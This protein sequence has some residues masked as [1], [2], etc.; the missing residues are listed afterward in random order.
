MCSRV[1][2]P[3]VP[4]IVYVC[5]LSDVPVALARGESSRGRVSM[6]QPA[7]PSRRSRHSVKIRKLGSPASRAHGAPVAVAAALVRRL[8]GD[9]RVVAA[10]GQADDRLAAAEE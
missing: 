1:G 9:A 2:M 8:I 7:A 3:I 5:D 4:P 10:I 6:L